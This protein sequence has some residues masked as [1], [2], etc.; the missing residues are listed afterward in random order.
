MKMRPLKII[1]RKNNTAEDSPTLQKCVTSWNKFT[2]TITPLK[3]L[4]I[5][6]RIRVH[7]KL[8]HTT[9]LVWWEMVDCGTGILS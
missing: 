8:K 3:Y 9:C 1:Q 7:R 2:K 4:R 6:R 5:R